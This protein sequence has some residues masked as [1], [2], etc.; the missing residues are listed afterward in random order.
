MTLGR[1]T[2]PAA[3]ARRASLLTWALAGIGAVAL[4][5]SGAAYVI[6]HSRPSEAD[7]DSGAPAVEIAL[8]MEAPRQ[9]TDDLPPGPES[10]AAA[11]SPAV[12]QTQTVEQSSLPKAN[13]QE[14]D[15]PDQQTSAQ[16][17]TE[18]KEEEKPVPKAA[19]AAESS[20]SDPTEATAPPT[21]DAAPESLKSTAPSPGIAKSVARVRAAW[22]KRLLAHLDRHKRYPGDGARRDIVVTLS[23]GLDRL[24][25]VVAANIAKGSGD[26]AFD[27]AALSMMR[28]SDPVPP[29]PPL[30]ADEGLAFTIPVVFKGQGAKSH[31][32]GR[33]GP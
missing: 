32:A 12:E 15:T 30:V 9:E 1:L 6:L 20:P 18:T 24:G 7:L 29:P 25:H 21:N 31:P 5:M 10:P 17:P 28:R 14:T 16:A 27:A 22:Q 26:P 13:P 2:E 19:K 4:H 8:D 33:G 3:I 23:F 11:A